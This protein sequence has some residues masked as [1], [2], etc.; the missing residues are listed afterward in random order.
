MAKNSTVVRLGKNHTVSIDKDILD[1]F[2]VR[3]FG[4]LYS[5]STLETNAALREI[6]TKGLSDKI[7]S[8]EVK[9]ELL[10]KIV[11]RAQRAIYIK[12]KKERKDEKN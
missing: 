3:S 12:L 11:P 2:S 8:K 9:V 6:F 5:E 7:T 10:T 4:T 1:F